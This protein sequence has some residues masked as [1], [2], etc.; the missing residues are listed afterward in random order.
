[1]AVEESC[2]FKVAKV[3]GRIVP[4]GSSD[5]AAAIKRRI[6]SSP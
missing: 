1:V 6:S 3:M 5:A 4:T 2:K